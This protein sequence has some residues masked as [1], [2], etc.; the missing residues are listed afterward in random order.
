MDR[1]SRIYSRDGHFTIIPP[2]QGQR[3]SLYLSLSV[4]WLLSLILYSGSCHEADEAFFFFFF[5][6][7]ICLGDSDRQMQ[8]GITAK[9]Q[10]RRFQIWLVQDL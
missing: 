5:F 4:L 6:R 8:L 2:E 7:F 1:R 3:L 10:T 9:T